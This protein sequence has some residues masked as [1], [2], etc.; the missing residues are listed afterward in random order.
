MGDRKRRKADC[1]YR[2][3]N[4]EWTRQ[5]FFTDIG[6]KALCLLCREHVAIFKEYNLKRHFATKHPGYCSGLSEEAQ[7]QKSRQLV[8]QLKK[9]QN[10]FTKQ[11]KT[12]EAAVK[13][14]FVV[15]YNVAKENKAF[16]DSEFVKKCML[17]VA[18]IICPE[19]KKDFENVSL[20]RR[21]T[22]R[23]IEVMERDL[24][25][26]LMHKSEQFD[27]YSLAL[28]D[29][30][31]VTDTAQLLIFIRGVNDEFDIT[32]ELLSME[33]MKDTTTGEDLLM[34]VKGC[35]EKYGLQWGKL[36]SVTTDGSPNLTGKNVGLQTRIQQ[37]VNE[38]CPGHELTFLHCIIHQEALCKNV[39][40]MDHV[41]NI[42]MK[43]VNFIRS[44]GLNHRQFI[45]LL[46]D[47]D[48]DHTDV[49][50]HTNVRWLSLGKVVKRVWNLRE[51][52]VLFL[53]MKD[54]PFPDFCD[55]R[56]RADLAFLVDIMDHMNNLNVTLQGKNVIVHEI[57]F[58]V[59]AFKRKLDL[60]S[61][62]LKERKFQHFPTLNTMTIGV[63]EARKYSKKVSDLRVEFSR[64]FGDF[65]R[66]E[67]KLKI[68]A[69][70]FTVDVESAPDNLQ[71]ELIDL[72]CKSVLKDS[73][74][75]ENVVQFFKSLSKSMFPNLRNFAKEMVVMF[76]S[77]YV[78]EQ[79]FSIMKQ[80][81]SD[82]RSRMTDEHLAAVLRI[83]TSETRPDFENLVKECKQ[84]QF[85]H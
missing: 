44:R 20:S 56:W 4:N 76:A 70:P 7:A 63:C 42:V 55:P 27:W 85:S 80:S 78:C 58:A 49:L 34:K 53:E 32:Q 6:N 24:L 13:A 31:D 79:T 75:P 72:Q 69:N 43:I 50:Y 61:T 71:L 29:S 38:A 37:T 84:H 59:Q 15:A 2:K 52:I 36:K 60:F 82:L 64:R 54:K 18:E 68:L 39:L 14:S 3:F 51:E 1:E 77:T 22:T 48:A 74:N 17:D 57:Y 25:E 41:V 5:Y 66:L 12:Q 65:R 45:S 35:I 67:N 73:F 46:T 9:Q 16:S 40:D 47:I 21:T 33:S 62:Q 83:F 81:K 10:L 11:S 30:T 8:E 26:Q 19:N 23:R 28:D